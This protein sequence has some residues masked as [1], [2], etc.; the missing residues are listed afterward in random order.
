MKCEHRRA[1]NGQHARKGLFNESFPPCQVQNAGRDGQGEMAEN[2]LY[3]G[4][5]DFFPSNLSDPP[6]RL[7]TA[8]Q[9]GPTIPDAN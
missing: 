8:A 1:S 4:Q 9:D 3:D 5:I 2:G 7:S 6:N